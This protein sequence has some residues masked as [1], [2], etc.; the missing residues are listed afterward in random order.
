MANLVI[1]GAQW[2]DEGKGKVVDLLAP[3]CRW[4]VRYQGGNNAGHTLVVGGRKVVLHLVPSGILHDG[5]QCVIGNGVV[6]DPWVLL[7][8]LDEL[9]RWGVEIGPERLVVSTAAH[10]ILPGHRALDK[11]RE[12]ALGDK[13]IGTTGRGIGPAYED[14]VGRRGLRVGDL[15]AADAATRIA[16]QL[17]A[18]NRLLVDTHGA[19][20][21]DVAGIVAELLSLREA[22]RAYVR[23]TVKL[24]SD[25][26]RG[27]QGVLF[28]GAQ[29]TFLDVDHGTY[30]FVTSSNTVAGGACTGAGVGPTAIDEVI[31]IAK[32]YATRVGAGPFPTEM[33]GPMAE[34]LRTAGGEFGATTGRPR[35]CGWF[36]A[37]A[38]RH[39]V[40]LNGLDRVAMMKLD[41]L[42]GMGRL[43]VATAYAG[44]D[45]VPA[46]A[47]ELAGVEPVWE[48]LE[49]WDADL[50]GCR[51]FSELPGQ[52]Q[53][54]VS[55]IEA[56][57]GV[58]VTWIGVGPGRE[59]MIERS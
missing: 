9:R 19:P 10:L 31:G 38:M 43:R 37:A 59:A 49:G 21:L 26:V 41:V 32:A 42:T 27:G 16:A 5:C 28:E 35:R 7:E 53:R 18:H 22:L 47:A 2:G 12:G 54:Y 30:P 58:P 52:A 3:R 8:E 36:D 6:V 50:S 24:M 55:R 40:M 56:L 1:V 4:V 14:K 34:R 45:E 25:A 15:Y 11:A 57:I 17:D 44:H 39:S 46:A 20:P 33:D 48:E 23:P 13:A 51:R 29:G